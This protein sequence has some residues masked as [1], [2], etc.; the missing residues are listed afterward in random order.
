MVQ[1]HSELRK[2]LKRDFSLV[3]LFQYPTISALAK[4]LQQQQ[5]RQERNITI[6]QRAEK[7][8]RAF[9]RQKDF[10]LRRRDENTRN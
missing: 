6:Q 8:I 2:V 1:V 10:A 9:K 7:Q 3:E 4:H 5:A